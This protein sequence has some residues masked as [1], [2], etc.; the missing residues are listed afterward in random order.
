MPTEPP[1]RVSAEE[2]KIKVTECRE[3]AQRALKAEH[4]AMLE[5]MATAW[6][7]I[8]RNLANGN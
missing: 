2:A 5:G 4:R 1:N 6:E 3:L 8:A 7:E